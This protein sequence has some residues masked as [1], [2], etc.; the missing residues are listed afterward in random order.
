MGYPGEQLDFSEV[1][2]FLGM[3]E[4]VLGS[5][6]TWPLELVLPLHYKLNVNVAKS[7]TSFYLHNIIFPG[8]GVLN[9]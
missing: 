2:S 1:L 5:I 8:F 3:L 6:L 9:F 4:T 7:L